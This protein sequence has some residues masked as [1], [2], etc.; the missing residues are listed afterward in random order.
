MQAKL[1]YEK[2]GG[3]IKNRQSRNTDKIGHKT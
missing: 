2:T 3:T 1:M